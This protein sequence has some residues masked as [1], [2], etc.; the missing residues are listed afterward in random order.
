MAMTEAPSA[1]AICTPN[2]PTPPTPTNTATS[3]APKPG[4]SNRLKRGSDRIGY[5]RQEIESDA[6]R[7]VF[8]NWTEPT[9]GNA[10]VRRKASIAVVAGHEL[11]PADR[12]LAGPAWSTVAA[13]DHSRNDY[14]AAFP[15]S[16]ALARCH[17]A[18][19]DFVS[20]SEWEMARAWVHRRK[21]S[22]HRYGRRRSRQPLLPPRRPAAQGGRNSCLSSR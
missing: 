18:A 1:A 16:G 17:N 6:W 13:G 20:E 2:P 12:R 11:P 22:R 7:Q 14:V 9:G 19:R 3:S 5:D 15:L 10:D 21:R 4:S 8:G